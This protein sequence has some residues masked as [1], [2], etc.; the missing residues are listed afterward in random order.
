MGIPHLDP[1]QMAI[2]SKQSMGELGPPRLSCR[3]TRTAQVA[4][5]HTTAEITFD[6]HRHLIGLLDQR[7][8]F[9]LLLQYPAQSGANAEQYYQTEQ[10]E[11]QQQATPHECPKPKSDAPDALTPDV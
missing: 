7:R 6:H 9:H 5:R 3:L 11:A 4:Q 1:H 8:V 2:G 10:R